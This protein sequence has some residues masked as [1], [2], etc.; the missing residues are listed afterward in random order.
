MPVQLSRKPKPLPP[1]PIAGSGGIV[2]PTRFAQKLNDNVQRGGI[3]QNIPRKNARIQPP[4][5]NSPPVR[6]I[7]GYMGDASTFPVYDQTGTVGD[8]RSLDPRSGVN[9]MATNWNVSTMVINQPLT[10][11]GQ[12]AITTQDQTPEVAPHEHGNFFSPQPQKINVAVRR[13]GG[14][15]KAADTAFHPK[16]RVVS[17]QTRMP[18]HDGKSINP[19]AAPMP[20][21]HTLRGL[22]HADALGLPRVDTVKRGVVG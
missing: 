6:V 19:S 11:Y 2:D 18:A 9:P 12:G 21:F 22:A 1:S 14:A 8:R 17:R 10:M 4:T 3:V 16:P 7:F 13:S 20:S 15:S 5:D